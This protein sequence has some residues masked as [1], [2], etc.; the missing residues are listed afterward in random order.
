MV[1]TALCITGQLTLQ[2]YTVHG[3][4]SGQLGGHFHAATNQG[5]PKHVL[6]GLVKVGAVAQLADHGDSILIGQKHVGM[7]TAANTTHLNIKKTC[8]SVGWG[9]YCMFGVTRKI[10]EAHCG[11]MS[12][13]DK[14]T[15]YISFMFIVELVIPIRCQGLN[16][17]P[18]KY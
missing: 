7:S 2:S 15:K 4:S 6:E 3:E 18:T 16:L 1:Y 13:R 9:I 10:R 5:L 12:H 14:Y 17:I 11:T 8:L